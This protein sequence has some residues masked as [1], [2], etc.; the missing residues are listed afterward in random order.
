M[1]PGCAIWAVSSLLVSLWW[2]LPAV[3]VVIGLLALARLTRQLADEAVALTL[4]AGSLD[5]IAVASD[6]ARQAV[7]RLGNDLSRAGVGGPPC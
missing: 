2:I 4:A 5:R 6:E 1:P 7:N 3:V